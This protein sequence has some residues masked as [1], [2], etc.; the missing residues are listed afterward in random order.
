MESVLKH[1]KKK[2]NLKCPKLALLLGVLDE[3]NFL[4]EGEV[5]VGNGR[6]V[7][8]VLIA[9]S[10]C[11]HPGDVQHARAVRRNARFQDAH[12]GSLVF[13][14]RGER[15]LP[16]MLAGGDLDGDEFYVIHDPTIVPFVKC[17]PPCDYGSGGKADPPLLDIA[18]WF[19]PTLNTP[20]PPV[21]KQLG[22]L[23]RMARDGNIV[24]KSADCWVKAVEKFGFDDKKTLAMA[25]IHQSALDGR[26]G[27]GMSQE[28]TRDMSANSH[29][30]PTPHWHAGGSGKPTRIY[31]S[32][33]IMVRR[34]VRLT[35]AVFCS[36]EALLEEQAYCNRSTR[37]RLSA[38]IDYISCWCLQTS[39]R[40]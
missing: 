10:P 20:P 30:V 8:D 4:N 22:V 13:S 32:K 9:R 11:N 6:I 29:N 39:T 35:S 3:H 18:A 15:P 37:T 31:L 16:D 38:N 1:V 12:S 17:R 27:S 23:A 2:R 40:C 25:A 36:R 33:S 21:G 26:K 28:Q 19:A 14:A 34:W 7:G 5:L 24:A